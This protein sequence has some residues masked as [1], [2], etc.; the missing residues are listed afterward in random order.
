MRKTVETGTIAGMNGQVEAVAVAVV[1]TDPFTRVKSGRT[2]IDKR[3][4]DGPVRLTASG[5]DGDTI[6][7]LANHGG[8][9]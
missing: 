5:V 3:P 2:G 4:V 9:D 6:C 8:P 1:R 7:D